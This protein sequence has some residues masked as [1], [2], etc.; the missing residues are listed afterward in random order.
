MARTCLQQAPTE[1]HHILGEF[2]TVPTTDLGRRGFRKS[3]A[4]PPH[5][6]SVYY[7]T[8]L[9]YTLLYLIVVY[10]MLFHYML[11]YYNPIAY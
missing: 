10:S 9:L 7:A 5:A 6:S 11:L 2:R 1:Q 4:A 3:P 8:I